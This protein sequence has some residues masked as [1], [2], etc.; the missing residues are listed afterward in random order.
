MIELIGSKN[1]IIINDILKAFSGIDT[2]KKR[3]SFFFP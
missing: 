2:L 1:T 3:I